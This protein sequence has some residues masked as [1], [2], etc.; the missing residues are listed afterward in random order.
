MIEALIYI[1]IYLKFHSQCI[2]LISNYNYRCRRVISLPAKKMGGTNPQPTHE[3]FPEVERKLSYDTLVN[4][5]ASSIDTKS[6]RTKKSFIKSPEE[7]TDNRASLPN[8]SNQLDHINLL[9]SSNSHQLD[10][11]TASFLY[12]SP[13]FN[14]KDREIQKVYGK[15]DK[16]DSIIPLNAHQCFYCPRIL[17][18][19]YFKLNQ[20]KGF[21]CESC[22]LNKKNSEKA[23]QFYNGNH[24]G[25]KRLKC[26]DRL[27][28]SAP[29]V[30][31]ENTIFHLSCSLR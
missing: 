5:D 25:F 12:S 18:S 6:K 23:F 11:K 27:M 1:V 9:H 21:I 8:Y 14:N 17:T 28:A 29:L 13:Y 10:R 2:C 19:N 15:P 22:L 26:C 3:K 20:N 7:E 4:S 16:R 31:K 30:I 24:L